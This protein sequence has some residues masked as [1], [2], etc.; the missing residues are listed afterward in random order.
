[1]SRVN[2]SILFLIVF[3]PCL[4]CDQATKSMA[5]SWPPDV[6]GWSFWGDTVRLEPVHNQGAFRWMAN[7]D[8]QCRGRGDH[9][10]G[11]HASGGGAGRAEACIGAPVRVRWVTV[12]PRV[13]E[14]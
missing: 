8:F 11:F 5:R 3:L 4:G 14:D 10:G 7:R 9:G 12:D 1:M 13:P 6:G 2:R